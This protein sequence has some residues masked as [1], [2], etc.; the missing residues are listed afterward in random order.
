MTMI[1]LMIVLSIASLAI[2]MASPSFGRMIAQRQSSSFRD[3]LMTALRFTKLQS[4]YLNRAVS[5]C[6]STSRSSC[7]SNNEWHK[8]FIVFIDENAIG[9]S[10]GDTIIREWRGQA[11][12]AVKNTVSAPELVRY[13]T[14]GVITH[15][16]GKDIVFCHPQKKAVD[17]SIH[18]SVTIGTATPKSS[19]QAGCS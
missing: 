11:A 6:P 10:S 9:W 15:G 1:E 2:A 17:Q 3:T 7:D 12:L 14:R 5:I 13:S 16:G 18:L 4:I 19:E 8:G